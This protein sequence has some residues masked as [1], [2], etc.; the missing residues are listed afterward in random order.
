[1]PGSGATTFQLLSC[2]VNIQYEDPALH[3]TFRYLVERAR[4]SFE[5]RKSLT[6]EVRGT[7][8]YDILEEGDAL[9]RVLTRADVLHVVYYRVYRRILERFV[10]AG[11]IT[12]HAALATINGRRTMILGHKGVG[13]TTLAARLLFAGHA[14]EGDEM[15]LVRN[16]L[17][18]AL[19]RAFHLKP[20]IGRFV[21][22]VAGIVGGLPKVF[23]GPVEISA[24]EPCECGFD[25]TIA[26]APVDR[27]VWI[28]PNHGGGT[29][30]KPR[31]SFATIRSIIECSLG[32][33]EA[34][35]ALVAAAS[36]LGRAGG[37]ELVMG[38]PHDAVHL[39]EGLEEASCGSIDI[40]L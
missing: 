7:G 3:R 17:A 21:P 6:Y 31:S 8:P 9:D 26:V 28:T 15:A 16:G 24:L 29:E 5:V 2:W 19:P 22:E 20:D 33:G 32:W 39:L 4:Q 10:L 12:L 18:L 34:R 40:A 1:V 35:E 27:V 36:S 38:N 14:V 23:S 30:L 37:H 11:W 25:W 13:K